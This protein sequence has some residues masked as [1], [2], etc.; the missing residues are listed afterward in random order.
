MIGT[1]DVLILD[2]PLESLDAEIRQ[3]VF[4]W[5]GSAVERGATVLVATHDVPAFE[6]KTMRT[7]HMEAG[8]IVS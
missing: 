6:R 7:L 4:R 8:R 2:D 3:S 5:V 1:P